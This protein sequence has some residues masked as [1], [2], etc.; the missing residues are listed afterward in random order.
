MVAIEDDGGLSK[1][2]FY[3][4]RR[5]NMALDSLKADLIR[6]NDLGFL[7][8]AWAT[9]ILQSANPGPAKAYLS[10]YPAEAVSSEFTSPWTVYPWDMETLISMLLTTPKKPPNQA[11]PNYFLDTTNF[12][13]MHTT[14]VKL[15]KLEDAEVLIM[16]DDQFDGRREMTRIGQRQFHWQQGALH[17][18]LIFRFLSVYNHPSANEA[19]KA[20]SGIS[21]DEFTLQGTQLYFEFLGRSRLRFPSFRPD[22]E[23]SSTRQ[24]TLDLISISVEQARI[25]ATKLVKN[26]KASEHGLRRVAYQPSLLR[27][28]PLIFDAK[29]NSYLAPIPALIISRITSGLYYDFIGN[30]TVMNRSEHLFEEYTGRIIEGYFPEL[31][32]LGQLKYGK[33]KGKQSD[34]PD[35]LVLDHGQLSI[36]IE[37]KSTKQTFAAQF[38]EDP[39]GASE[40][41]MPQL[42]KGILQLW[43]F[44]AACSSGKFNQYQLRPDARG[45]VL[46]LDDWF[47]LDHFFKNEA[48]RL[49]TIQAAKEGIP[50]H[51]LDM[52]IVFLSSKGLADLMADTD[53]SGTYRVLDTA[54]SVLKYEGFAPS[55]IAR[56]LGIVQPRTK[57]PLDMSEVLPWRNLLPSR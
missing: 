18:E 55:D 47:L 26:A 41:A 38:A 32:A 16:A 57:F 52:P 28:Y 15:R 3:K 56:D 20:K 6:T 36:V 44:F 10:K 33:T 29:T 8:L 42:T 14:V 12:A 39:L 7:E 51:I 53:L 4:R 54:A 17:P 31:K 34:T 45:M 23:K 49:A 21:I 40:K 35:V 5:F 46:T 30:Q 43:R 1:S 2:P 24:K 22:S 19:F 50:S 11:G 25:E 13:A 27:K 9:G 37:C 48:R